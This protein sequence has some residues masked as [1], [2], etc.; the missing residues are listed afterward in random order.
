[1]AKLIFYFGTMGSGKTERLIYWHDKVHKQ[2]KNAF[3]LTSSVDN[4]SALYSVQSR[5]GQKR[6]AIPIHNEYTAEDVIKM[7][8][9]CF[10]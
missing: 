6:M 8:S 10:L 1:M 9:Q 7:V 5:K 4:R 2:G 3:I